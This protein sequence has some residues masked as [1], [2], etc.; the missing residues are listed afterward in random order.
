MKK[1]LSKILILVV[2]IVCCASCVLFAGC[3]VKDSA[4]AV[5]NW[6]EA[7]AKK[8]VDTITL[9][10]ATLNL[11][12][13]ATVT[14]DANI[15]LTRTYVGE[16]SRFDVTANISKVDLGN[17]NSLIGAI[18][19]LVQGLTLNLDKV[20]EVKIAAG[21]YFNGNDKFVLSYHINDLNKLLKVDAKI[22]NN[23]DGTVELTKAQLDKASPTIF[24]FLKGLMQ[25]QSLF[26]LS[27]VTKEGVDLSGATAFAPVIDLGLGIYEKYKATPINKNIGTAETPDWVPVEFVGDE[28][29]T[30]TIGTL[31]AR[32]IKGD[33]DEY[34]PAT[35]A[36]VKTLINGAVDFGTAKV[37]AVF[38]SKTFKSITIVDTAKINLS[39]DLFNNV[40]GLVANL[41]PANV[42]GILGGIVE[43]VAKD[44]ISAQFPV[45]QT[46]TFEISDKIVMTPIVK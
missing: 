1:N 8:A 32:V 27:T 21:I 5:A 13:F 31:V 36:D 43:S 17:L 28:G 25:N 37:S 35:S 11:G 33:L 6:K 38:G 16:E 12:T 20:A 26:D 7:P 4:T 22:P 15:G 29:I 30:H 19:G 24:T 3:G 44:G 10:G 40:Y 39:K 9:K 34:T 18:G 2:A 23:I 42:A 46:T 14:L 41:I 45:N